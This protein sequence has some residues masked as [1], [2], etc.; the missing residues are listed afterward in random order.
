MPGSK[1]PD[2]NQITIH[3]FNDGGKIALQTGKPVYAMQNDSY[4]TGILQ[5]LE[6]NS[7]P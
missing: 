7:N 1:A 5:E 3:L 6:Y 2:P 4:C